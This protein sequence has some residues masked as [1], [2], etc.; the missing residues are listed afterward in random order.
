[1]VGLNEQSKVGQIFYRW[2][3]LSNPFLCAIIPQ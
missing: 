2:Y 3:V 1:M